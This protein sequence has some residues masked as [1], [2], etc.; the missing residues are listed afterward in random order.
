M[1]LTREELKELVKNKPWITPFKKMLAMSDP[2]GAYLEIHE[3]YS[4]PC[5]GCAAWTT[6]NVARNSPIVVKARRDGNRN[7]YIVRLGDHQKVEGTACIEVAS[8]EGSKVKLV[9]SGVAGAGVG[10]TLC[11]G[12]A[13]GVEEV[14]ILEMGGGAKVG[15]SILTLPLKYKLCVGIDDTD[16]K[17]EGATWCLANNIAVEL[18]DKGLADYVF[19]TLTQLYKKNPHRTSNCVASGIVLAVEPQKVD[20]AVKYLEE[21]LRE[22]TLSGHTGMAYRVGVRVPPKLRGFT[23]RA[24]RGMVTFDDAVSVAR[25]VNASLKPITGERGCI[26]AL[27]SLGFIDNPDKAAK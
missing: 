4:G 22:R 9:C 5:F 26:G 16:N 23:R 24:K 7:I 18:E 25:E 6:L 21:A 27:A 17:E 11:R 1:K 19:L 2:T 14:E 15:R 3:I 20:I 12:L 8:I 10:F 13:D